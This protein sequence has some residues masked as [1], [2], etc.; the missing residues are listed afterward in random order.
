M[1]QPQYVQSDTLPFAGPDELLDVSSLNT[2]LDMLA[3]IDSAEELTLLEL[4]TP[5]QKRQVWDA[6][7]DHLK[8]KLKQI[9]A[10][11]QIS[12]ESLSESSSEQ[13]LAQLLDQSPDLSPEL[14]SPESLQNAGCQD[15]RL[16]NDRLPNDRLLNSADGSDVITDITDA[17]ATELSS[18]ASDSS[19]F[20]QDDLELLDVSEEPIQPL[21][22]LQ[23][24]DHTLHSAPAF[25]IGDRVV[26]LAKPHLTPTE[27]KAIWEVVAIE[28]HQAQIATTGLADRFYPMA[29]MMLYP[30]PEF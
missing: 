30:D 23:Q 9:R 13:L 26:L 12:S 6:T 5:A 21:Q 3:V 4:L 19:H 8:R 17:V 14:L 11:A 27:L 18:L 16:P 10:Q 20:E 7:P 1:L 28:E 24:L 29:W 25:Q 2:V 22:L 15:D